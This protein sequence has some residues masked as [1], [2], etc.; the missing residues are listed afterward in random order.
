MNTHQKLTAARERV[1][2]IE[3]EIAALADKRKARLVANDSAAQ[4]A[5]GID[6]QVADLQALAEIERARIEA[7]GEEVRK[8]DV[9][10]V[11]KRKTAQIERLQKKL[12]GT[13]DDAR[14]L[15]ATI[16]RAIDLFHGICKARVETMPVFQ[17][18]D[19]EVAA[20]V[21]NHEGAALTASSV[22]ALLSFELYRQGARVVTIPGAPVTEPSWPRPICPRLDL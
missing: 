21:N 22:A 6:K 5:A 7:L 18:G 2:S 13:V 8:A 1:A 11:I 14:L 20:A 17:L 15:E 10:A 12:E 9:Q 16:T 4:I 19:S 3:A